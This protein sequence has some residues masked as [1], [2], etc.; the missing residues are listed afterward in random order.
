[1][2]KHLPGMQGDPGWIA[3]LGRPPG[4]PGTLMLSSNIFITK[5]YHIS[6]GT[7]LKTLSFSETLNFV[8][9]LFL[10]NRAKLPIHKDKTNY[11]FWTNFSWLNFCSNWLSFFTFWHNKKDFCKS[12]S[13]TWMLD[14]VSYLS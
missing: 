13:L 6:T 3:G 4:E 9:T 2:V 7:I 8:T 11:K 1:M 14:P 5:I 10:F 12:P